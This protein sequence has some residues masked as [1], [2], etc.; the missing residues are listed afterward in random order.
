MKQKA[1][2]EKCLD[3]LRGEAREKGYQIVD[4]S[5]SWPNVFFVM[6]TALVEKG[7]EE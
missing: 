4:I 7:V 1:L 2:L 3:R 5:V 6:V